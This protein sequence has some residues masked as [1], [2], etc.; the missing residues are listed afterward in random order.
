MIEIGILGLGTVGTGVARVIEESAEQ[1]RGR[2]G[3]ELKVRRAL[4]RT[5]RGPYRDILTDDFTEIERD[6]EIR[7]VVETMGGVEPALDYTKR[8]F[9]AGKHVV[10][11]NKQLVAEH[12]HELLELARRSGVRYLFEGSVAGGIPVLH[13][14]TQCLAANRVDEIYGILNGTTNYILTKMRREGTSFGE[15][16]RQAQ[17]QGYAEADPTADVEGVDAG[18]KICILADLAFGVRTD[19]DEVSM[20]G[21]TAVA[22]EDLSAAGAA[23]YRIRLLGRCLRT[24]AG[25]TAFVAPHLVPPDCPVA[26][27]DDVNNAV[28]VRCSAAGDVMFYGRGAGAMPTAS[29]CVSD[30]LECLLYDESVPAPSW[31]ADTAGFFDPALLESRWYFR[32]DGPAAP[33][34]GDVTPLGENAFL[35]GPMSGK[36]AGELRDRPEVRSAMR[37]LG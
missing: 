35:T 30:V 32:T 11:A 8:C 29:A 21:I 26:G 23:G 3:E 15:A 22:P 25:H 31:S 10:T 16:L 33:E 2:L 6:P 14:L 36:R 37:V 17:E 34:F 18:R 19:P 20:E 7:V 12:G 1:I 9:A 4:A 24:E 5:V 13:P 27:V 28:V